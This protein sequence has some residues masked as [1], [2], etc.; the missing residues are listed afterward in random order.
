MSDHQLLI[1][2]CVVIGILAAIIFVIDH[3]LSELKFR[4]GLAKDKLD[5]LEK[6][7]EKRFNNAAEMLDLKTR[8]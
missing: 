6:F 1:A 7:T 4:F 3:Q 5:W 8:R 2:A